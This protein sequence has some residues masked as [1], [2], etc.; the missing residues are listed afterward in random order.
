MDFACWD[1]Y[2]QWE[3]TL[4]DVETAQFFAFEHDLN[5]RS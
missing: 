1:S 4:N 5:A 3:S 2:P